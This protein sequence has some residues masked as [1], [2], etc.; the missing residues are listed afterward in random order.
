M[1]D[2]TQEYFDEK[3][4]NLATKDDLV[5]INNKL[6]VIMASAVTRDELR[7]LV[8]QLKEQGIELDEKKIFAV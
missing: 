1:T 2:L 7:N 3:V 8:R 6:D 4:A 5:P